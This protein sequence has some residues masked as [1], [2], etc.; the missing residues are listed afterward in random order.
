MTRFSETFVAVVLTVLVAQA[1]SAQQVRTVTVN[2]AGETV[3]VE[4]PV[5]KSA[6]A[7]PADAKP[8]SPPGTPT[9][10]NADANKSKDD[11][12]GKEKDG[13]KEEE[14]DKTV[15]RPAAS[16][17]NPA[18]PIAEQVTFDDAGA[19]TFD[20]KGQPWES[21]LQWLADSSHLSFDW[22]ELPG[23]ALNLTT[24]RAYTLEEARDIVN[25]HLLTRGYTMIVNGE[26]MDVVKLT[27]IH[28]SLVPRIAADQ[29][30]TT[31]DHTL[32]K[33]SFDLDWL[34]ADEV[35]EELAPLLSKAGKISKL[36]RTNRLEIMDTAKTLRD[37]NEIL[38]LEQSET[39]QE[40]L[41]RV[42][43][44]KHRRA[45]EVITLL[46]DL[47]G[48]ERQGGGG[49]GGMN[50][51]DMGQITNMMRQM[52]QQMQQMGN[53][54][55]GGSKGGGGGGGN[56]EPTKTRLVLNQ[57]ENMILAQAM[58]DQMAIIENAILQIDVPV[59]ASNSLIQ[60]INKIKVYRLDTVDPQTLVDLLQELGDLAPG[61]VLKVGADKKS[62][63]AFAN[64]ADHLT[65]GTLVERL[66]QSG[67]SVEV[68]QLRRLDAEY[69]GG[70]IR[71]LM[72]PP[73]PEEN[74]S[75]YSFY[76]R[77][78]SNQPKANDEKAFKVEADIENNRLL[79]YA[80]KTEM[81][82]IMI[83]LQKLGE[84]PD[85]DAMDNGIRVF[86]LSPSD[87]P[88]EVIE[89]LKQLWRGD[90]ELQ[91]DF[92]EPP[93]E[94]SEEGDDGTEKDATGKP[95][96]KQPVTSTDVKTQTKGRMTA[97]EF[98]AMLKQEAGRRG[99]DAGK[100][101]E[102]TAVSHAANQRRPKPDRSPARTSPAIPDRNALMLTMAEDEPTTE[103]RPPVRFSL[104][105]DGRLVVTCD[106]KQ[107]L[108]EVEELLAKLMRPAPNYK[109][110]K[111]KFATPS[112][113]TLNLED[114]FKAEEDTETSMRYDWNW[115][116]VPSTKKKSGAATLG[117]RRTPTFIYDNFTSTI[118]V[119]DADRRQLQVIEDLIGIYDVPEPADTRSMRVTKIFKLENTKAESVAQAVK[120]V[121]RDLLSANDKAL[122]KKGGEQQTQT[123]VYSYFGSGDDDDG[124]D[125]NP[126]RFKGL[127]SIGVD[128]TSDTLVVS[129]TA[130]LM[131]I[132]SELVLELDKAAEQSSLV[133]VVKVGPT[134]DIQL[135]QERLSK[136]LGNSES[137]GQQGKGKNG[138]ENGQGFPQGNQQPRRDN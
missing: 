55:R 88:R 101:A 132:V 23:D 74:N 123:R 79:V 104:S 87:D 56:R 28:S 111:L 83:L 2:E 36:S 7:K 6:P 38:K 11:E 80:N 116:Y 65:V 125:E 49:G 26:Q 31:M 117:R 44:L 48:L 137:T 129:S 89:R 110:F 106:D 94:E 39:G 84:I 25:R 76:S 82:E 120:D 81:D 46:M 33:V 20:M 27:D 118:L 115:G 12:K 17:E 67:R 41:L 47:L 69:V 22:Q 29:L 124:G 16:K 103:Q 78:S 13:K 24:T 53:A 42:F 72:S 10:G 60:N 50:M 126:I 19:V 15:K 30:D 14:K 40:Q 61:T 45:N 99:S 9:P 8:G 34:I 58:P 119:R 85:P 75:R 138:R 63:M 130:S 57:R 90:N 59:E 113:I 121:F 134:V 62:I 133:H 77:Y 127:L 98:F 92:P 71:A 112:W 100:S 95:A 97:D 66:D 105:P 91:F 51:G 3:V 114:Y 54:A 37:I 35:V 70:T 21:V 5:A 43:P 128:P 18:G 4:T 52:Q 109:V 96:T 1:V 64:L 102:Q 136:A 107:A 108:M 122:E 135:I 131:D 86:E 73:P 32:C 93:A 68:I